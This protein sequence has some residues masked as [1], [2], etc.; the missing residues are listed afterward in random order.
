MFSVLICLYILVFNILCTCNGS[1]R[2]L[3]NSALHFLQIHQRRA[4]PTNVM[5]ELSSIS[6]LKEGKL[7]FRREGA[8]S[9][10]L[11]YRSLIQVCVLSIRQTVLPVVLVL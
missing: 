3:L 10:S 4:V 1:V 7:E 5:H 8:G 6:A 2:N 11:T 9:S